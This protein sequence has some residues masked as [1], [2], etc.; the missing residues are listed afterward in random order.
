MLGS[1]S[2]LQLR[3]SVRTD[4]GTFTGAMTVSIRSII[5]SR[6]PIASHLILNSLTTT[7]LDDNV[8]SMMNMNTISGA[9]KIT[10]SYSDLNAFFFLD[11]YSYSFRAL[12]FDNTGAL[13]LTCFSNEAHIIVIECAKV[14][15][16]L[17][18]TH[19]Y[20]RLF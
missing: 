1:L 8:G 18:Y 11:L 16:E 4:L 7:G 5:I 15:S 17:D 14:V 10:C 6:T 9:T 3:I 13:I 2:F 20:H 12:I 19:T